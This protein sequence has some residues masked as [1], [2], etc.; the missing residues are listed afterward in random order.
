[1]RRGSKGVLHG[2][3]ILRGRVEVG[4]P[5]EIAHDNGKRLATGHEHLK[6]IAFRKAI[7]AT[8]L[9]LPQT[10][11]GGRALRRNGSARIEGVAPIKNAFPCSKCRLPVGHQ[12]IGKVARQHISRMKAGLLVAV[13]VRRLAG[14]AE[15]EASGIRTM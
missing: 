11:S 2:R 12:L 15:V 10:A 3:T 1:M 8:H 4:K 9:H 6:F 5:H 7:P 13:I 14:F